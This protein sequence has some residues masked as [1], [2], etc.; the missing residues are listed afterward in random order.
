MFGRRTP[1]WKKQPDQPKPPPP[2]P[3]SGG[4]LCV[5]VLT[6]SVPDLFLAAGFFITWHRPYTFGEFA[7]KH[8]MALMLLEFLVVHATGFLGALTS[9][10]TP[11]Y[12]RILIYSVLMVFYGLMSFGMLVG[13]GS[14]W[15]A[16]GFTL[17][18]LGKAPNVFR[19]QHG[20]DAM[21]GI[22]SNWA[23]MVCLYLF[24]VF[25]TAVYELP[26]YGVTPEVIAAQN[27]E[28]GGEW[29]EKPYTVMAFGAIYFTGLALLNVVTQYVTYRMSQ[30][31][32]EGA[33]SAR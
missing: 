28:T 16:L 8:F 12:E 14:Y 23:A 32:R 7:V 11:F 13:M 30:N 19:P 31:Y 29:P 26:P 18:L 22:M 10:D 1:W 15:P 3:I 5:R 33:T 25:A 2:K 4:E 9:R 24:G 27:F 21:M 17:M 6:G 20:D